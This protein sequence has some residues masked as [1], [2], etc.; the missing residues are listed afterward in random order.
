MKSLPGRLTRWEGEYC[1]CT[2]RSVLGLEY[3]GWYTGTK[4]ILV[5]L[6]NEGFIPPKRDG[7]LNLNVS[8]S[9]IQAACKHHMS[10]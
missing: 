1:M 4:V 10:A 3:H 6:V 5:S 9:V 7:T 8:H 2:S